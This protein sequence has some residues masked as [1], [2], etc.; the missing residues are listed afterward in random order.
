MN[1][2][3]VW[4]ILS[5]KR[6]AKKASFLMV[7]LV[8]PAAVL[9]IRTAEESGKTEVRIAVYAAD[10]GAR[11]SGGELSLEQ[12]LAQRLVSRDSGREGSIFRF[13]LCG[14]EQQVKDEVASRRAE[15]G[16]VIGEGLRGK[17]SDKDYKRCIRVYSAPSTVAAGLSTEVVF[18]V[19]MEIYD[20]ELFAGYVENSGAFD[21]AAPAG[22]ARRE[23]LAGE[24]AE[25]FEKWMHNGSTFRFV[26]G[27]SPDVEEGAESIEV[28]RADVAKGAGGTEVPRADVAERAGGIELP[29]MDVAERAGGTRE[30]QADSPV[31]AEAGM[32]F[33]VRGIVAVYVFIIGIYAAA[34]SL[35]DEKRGLFLALP[36]Y[37]RTV[38]RLAAMAAP[39]SLSA[40]S[41]FAALF[42]GGVMAGIFEEISAMSLYLVAVILF[43]WVLRQVSR[44]PEMVCAM[45]PFFLIGSLAFCPVVIDVGRYLPLA[46]AARK[47]FLPW[48]YLRLFS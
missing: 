10:A 3:W 44:T 30:P 11:E 9:G 26:S 43:S 28:P 8:L 13:Y 31:D 14:S 24:A 46:A 35:A 22:S 39:V 1:K 33:P 41:G 40:L 5:C 16:Y 48:Y 34:M 32:V 38:C 21:P 47:L 17:L 23:E 29:R 19:L 4:F 37:S 36:F 18:S 20:K 25:L 27:V 12:M 15:C 2:V 7:L 45:I 42:S 6:Y